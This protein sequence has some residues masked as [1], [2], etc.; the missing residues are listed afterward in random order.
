VTGK[1]WALNVAE[2]QKFWCAE[3]L[4]SFPEMFRIMYQKLQ[5]MAYEGNIYGLF[6]ELR[7]F[8]EAL[9]R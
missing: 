3:V 2:Q 1:E 8:Y 6:L 5:R 9:I 4:N 7:Y